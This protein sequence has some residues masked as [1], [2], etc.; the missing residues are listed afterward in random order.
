MKFHEISWNLVKFLKSYPN[1]GFVSSLECQ[2]AQPLLFPKEY[3]GFVTG[4]GWL[5]T[6]NIMI[7][8]RSHGILRNIMNF[9]KFS[10]FPCISQ[11]FGPAALVRKKDSNSYAFSMV[12]VLIFL[13]GHSKISFSIKILVPNQFFRD[14]HEICWNLGAGSDFMGFEA[15]LAGP[16]GKP[17]YSYRNIKVS[18]PPRTTTIT[19]KQ[20]NF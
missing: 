16:G 14:F 3:Q 2:A 5:E 12:A 15:S 1:F 8:I 13:P 4:C 6:Q 18:E 7:F 20:R 9:H 19:P 10:W 17:W 11:D